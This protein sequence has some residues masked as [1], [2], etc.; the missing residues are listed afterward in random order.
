MS[1]GQTKDLGAYIKPIR[2]SAEVDG[3]AAGTGDNTEVSS[4]WI[5]TKGF[6]GLEFVLSF[7]AAL[8]ATQT[9]AVIANVQDADEIDGTG[10]AD[11]STAFLSALS[12]TVLATGD[13][14]GSTE[15]GEFQIGIDLTMC[16]RYVRVQWTPDLS[17]TGTDTFKIGS[18]YLLTGAKYPPAN[19]ARVT[20]R[21]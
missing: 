15:T 21:A 14:G 18:M 19:A 16:K 10:A 2:A 3:T 8:Q 7:T 13:T 4:A 12:S 17:A 5:D 6:D 11:V 9:L 1:W 20:L